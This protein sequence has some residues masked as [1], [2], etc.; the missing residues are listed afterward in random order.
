MIVHPI[1]PGGN[2]DLLMNAGSSSVIYWFLQRYGYVR[3]LL[4]AIRQMLI[5]STPGTDTPRKVV[6]VPGGSILALLLVLI[7]SCSEQS[8]MSTPVVTTPTP[9]VNRVKN[10]RILYTNDEEGF[11]LPNQCVNTGG[12]IGIMEAWTEHED[13]NNENCLI[14]SGGDIFTSSP[15]SSL[16][17]GKSTVHI[18]QMMGYDAIGLGNH[19]LDLGGDHAKSLQKDS[20]IPWL[21]ANYITSKNLPDEF[22]QAATTFQ[23]QGITVGVVGLTT[24]DDSKIANA[25]EVLGERDLDYEKAVYSALE[26]MQKEQADFNILIGNTTPDDLA[27]LSQRNAFMVL[28][29]GDDQKMQ[30][31]QPGETQ[32]QTVAFN[33]TYT[34]TRGTILEA[35]A[36]WAGYLR[37]DLKIDTHT[38]QVQDGTYTFKENLFT[39]DQDEILAKGS[40]DPRVQAIIDEISG[41][42]G[43]MNKS[44][45]ADREPIG[46]MQDLTG[47]Q[48][49]NLFVRGWHNLYPDVDMTIINTGAFRGCLSPG[50]FYDI[51]IRSIIPF[52]NNL[53]ILEVQG[54]ILQQLCGAHRDLFVS[55]GFVCQLDGARIMHRDGSIADIDNDRKYRI[56]T[57]DFVAHGG[58]GFPFTQDMQLPRPPEDWK[59]W[60]D[61]SVEM[62]KC[63][64]TNEVVPLTADH[65]MACTGSIEEIE[66]G[67]GVFPITGEIVYSSEGQQ[68]AINPADG[69]SRVIGAAPPLGSIMG[70]NA[71]RIWVEREEPA[72]FGA[73]QSFRILQAD[74]NDSNQQVLLTSDAF[75]QQFNLER[76][77]PY[78]GIHH[79]LVLS[80]DQTRVFFAPYTSGMGSVAGYAVHALDLVSRQ[81]S[82]PLVDR[83]WNCWIATDG[84]RVVF[85]ERRANPGE[86]GTLP[87]HSYPTFFRDANGTISRISNTWTDDVVWLADGRFVY[88]STALILADANGSTLRTI[89]SFPEEM[90][91]TQLVASPDQQHLAYL[92]SSSP[93]DTPPPPATLWVVNLDGSEQRAI[94]TLPGDAVDLAWR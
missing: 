66:T 31:I 75:Y 38:G 43:W 69:S 84:Q 53:V 62:F 64:K 3:F 9:D 93:Y 49:P 35:P 50:T 82:Q 32:S 25:D 13:C 17:G 86:P 57:I 60:H 18:M 90:F 67:D 16:F 33:K 79:E 88:N 91:L 37:I 10:L 70:P 4:L 48:V 40:T 23:K 78:D 74:L 61:V 42:E 1:G 71:T 77:A 27:T 29:G 22:L 76:F 20:G 89:T 55:Q 26:Q 80:A 5:I 56:L 72:N 63:L 28:L 94:A 14:L 39:I 83:V 11:L 30:V 45:F 19:E 34:L 68:F 54:E 36:N 7:S 24:S 81:V 73:L 12:A 41:P 92:T 87:G 51:D 44:P 59:D 46:Y 85:V 47:E 58:D 8:G 6:S 21:S 2:L 15:I 65:P 52:S